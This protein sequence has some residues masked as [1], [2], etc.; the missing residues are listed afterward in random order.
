MNQENVHKLRPLHRWTHTRTH[1]HTVGL[2]HVTA[3]HRCC[4]VDIFWGLKHRRAT[5]RS[6]LSCDKQLKSNRLWLTGCS[7]EDPHGLCDLIQTLQV[8]NSDWFILTD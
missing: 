4:H 3:A 7:A 2:V 1:A 8:I 5:A 6:P